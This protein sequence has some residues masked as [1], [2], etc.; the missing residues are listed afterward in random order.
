MGSVK[1]AL[2]C[3]MTCACSG[4]DESSNKES[5]LPFLAGEVMVVGDFGYAYGS[6]VQESGQVTGGAVLVAIDLQRLFVDGEP[7]TNRRYPSDARAANVTVSDMQNVLVRHRLDDGSLVGYESAAAAAIRVHVL[8]VATKPMAPTIVR[9]TELPGTEGYFALRTGPLGDGR[10][11]IS[12]SET[13]T[14]SAMTIVMNPTTGEIASTNAGLECVTGLVA[15]AYFYCVGVNGSVLSFNYGAAGIGAQ[16]SSIE[17]PQAGGTL[18]GYLAL[19]GKLHVLDSGLST[20]LAPAIYPFQLASDGTMVASTRL[21][22][23][24]LGG[25]SPPRSGVPITANT[26]LLGTSRGPVLYDVPGASAL[27]SLEDL[28]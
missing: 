4:D 23:P 10:V 27:A 20:P 25:Y 6:T 7:L 16:V 1:V 8:D 11:F 12:A 13:E 2:I 19:D 28:G 14:P 21:P 9:T 18:G 22:T 5:T 24:E 15:G 17:N 3:L 26:V